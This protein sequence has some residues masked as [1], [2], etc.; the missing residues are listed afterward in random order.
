MNRIIIPALFI[1]GL[2]IAAS[3]SDE[4]TVHLRGRIVGM[5]AMLPGGAP[6]EHLIADV[7][8]TS[9]RTYEV[10]LGIATISPKFG[11]GE[12]IAVAG[13]YGIADGLPLIVAD[14]F[15]DTAHARRTGRAEI[16][17]PPDSRITIQSEPVNHEFT[18]PDRLPSP[19]YEG[20]DNSRA[21]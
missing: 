11:V 15:D 2:C 7:Q 10:D 17:T 20:S 1:C 14:S 12:S 4:P 6:F 8:A 5:K 13:H 21:R 3:A 19:Q 16:V 9:G 18:E